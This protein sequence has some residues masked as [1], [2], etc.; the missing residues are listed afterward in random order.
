VPR[1]ALALM[2]AL[3]VTVSVAAC[4]SS[5]DD[6]ATT[7]SSGGSSTAAATQEASAGGGGVAHAQ[8]QIEAYSKVPDF[9]IADAEPVDVAALK[10]KHIFNIPITSGIPFFVETDKIMQKTAEEQGLKFTEFTNDGTP[11]QWADGMNQAIAQ[12][13]DII[14]LQ[15]S[16]DPKLIVPQLK[17]AKDA[18]IPVT[19]THF[20]QD[21]TTPPDEVLPYITGFDTVP[22]ETVGRLEADW[23][24]AK[25]DGK[26]NV[27]VITADEVAASAPI[28]KGIKDEFATQCPDCTVDVVNVPIAQWGSKIQPEVQSA[29]T[30]NPNLDWV[31][32][33]YDG[34]STPAGA[35]IQAAGKANDIKVATYNGTPAMLKQVADQPW[36][37]MDISESMAWLAYANL[38]TVFRGLAGQD[39]I[40]EKA[41]LR[42][43]SKDNIAEAGN[44]PTPNKGLGDS[45]LAGYEKLWGL[46]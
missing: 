9:Q 31:I 17:K 44:P 25:S 26:A 46:Q 18:G 1:R 15:G 43:M 16:P 42:I 21:G 14:N 8:E 36:M 38:D 29:I 30:K 13:V 6:S 3:A 33:I 28:M 5:D 24:I 39:S 2:A 40:D 22:F 20:Y 45:Y 7:A 23:T 27:L 41:P 10:G 37:D 35:G 11:Q 34:M 32:P 4:G 19:I 12:K